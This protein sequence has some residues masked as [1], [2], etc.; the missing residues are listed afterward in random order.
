MIKDLIEHHF[1]SIVL[2]GDFNPKIF[3]P[4]WFVQNDLIREQEGNDVKDLVIHNEVVSFN[5]DWLSIQVTREKIVVLSDHD[6]YFQLLYDFVVGTFKLLKHTPIRMLGINHHI[7][8]RNTKNT[9]WNEFSSTIA[10]KKIWEKA[11][12]KGEYETIVIKEDIE[13]YNG[14][15]KMTMQPSSRIDKGIFFEVNNHFQVKEDDKKKI[16]C[17][18]I[19]TILENEWDNVN[20]NTLQLIETVWNH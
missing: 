15:I 8:I 7:H 19:I 14:F 6:A 10:P 3:Q 18:E 4:N 12:P 11:F 13:K 2:I 5:L 9:N 16:G 17:I 1:A 20:R